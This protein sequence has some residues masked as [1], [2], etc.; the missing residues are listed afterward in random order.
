MMFSNNTPNKIVLTG[1]RATGKSTLGLLAASQLEYQF[2]DTDQVLM[3]Q[4][5]TT[6]AQIVASHG[7]PFFR[8]AE[9]QL[10][11]EL[12]SASEMVIATG[13]GAIEHQVEWEL[14]RRESFVVWLD[15]D[16]ATINRRIVADSTSTAQ[17]PALISGSSP[18]EEI[19]QLL[20]KRA[21]LY[22]L[23]SDLRLDTAQASMQDLVV[24]VCDAFQR[25]R[26]QQKR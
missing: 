6:I 5:G 11:A 15:A 25:R 22:A 10:I 4:L 24:S 26:K 13:G 17:R 1:L 16:V 20:R 2:L 14:L 23:G 12:S 9:A 18:E 3:Q 8:R 19:S 7:W 21:P